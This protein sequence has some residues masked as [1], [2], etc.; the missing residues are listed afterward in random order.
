[1]R[2]LGLLFTVTLPLAASAQPDSS[3][4]RDD[5]RLRI[6]LAVGRASLSSGGQSAASVG[7][8]LDAQLALRRSE[9]TDI[10]LNF[11]A[12]PF[13][14]QNPNRDEA[15]RAYHL[16]LGWQMGSSGFERVY[17]RPS[18]G[19]VHRPWS[20]TDVWVSSETSI[21]L[22][23]AG[24]REA[25]RT[26]RPSVVIEGFALLSGAQELGTTLIGVTVAASSGRR[27]L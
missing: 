5:T 4:S 17:V 6:G 27:R 2:V 13:R 10:V 11:L 12:Q 19:V 21:V 26:S 22:G 16:M 15:Y 9:R 8:L 14:V 23:L 20:G 1:M 24:G 18:I 7:P 25:F 3:P